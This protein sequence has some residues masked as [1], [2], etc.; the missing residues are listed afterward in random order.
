MQ[1]QQGVRL[2]AKLKKKDKIVR[3]QLIACAPDRALGQG[4]VEACRLFDVAVPVVLGKHERDMAQF[5]LVSFTPRDFVEPFAYSALELSLI[6]PKKEASHRR[7][8]PLSL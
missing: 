7:P 2:W 3:D 8:D 1:N 5:H 6:F 4:L